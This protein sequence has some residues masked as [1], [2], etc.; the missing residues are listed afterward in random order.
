M[1][2]DACVDL[3]RRRDPQGYYVLAAK[4]EALELLEK[5]GVS[6]EDAGSFLL[7]RVRSRSLAQRVCEMLLRKGLLSS[8]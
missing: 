4:R 7:V 6:V 3:L 2:G 8:P 5:L 1:R